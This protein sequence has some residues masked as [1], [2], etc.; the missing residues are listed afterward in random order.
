[1]LQLKVKIVKQQAARDQHQRR[2]NLVKY[3]PNAAR[4]V[5]TV[6]ESMAESR[7]AGPKRKRMQ[8]DDDIL[9]PVKQMRTSED[10]LIARLTEHVEKID[11]DMARHPV[12]QKVFQQHT[13]ICVAGTGQPLTY[14]HL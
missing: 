13:F 8:E 9:A 10:T 12:W 7:V 3:I 4:A 11:S 5:F 1:M 6:L 14:D 2:K